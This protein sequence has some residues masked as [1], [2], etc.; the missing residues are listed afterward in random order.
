MTMPDF[1]PDELPADLDPTD[2]AALAATAAHLLGVRPRPS[3]GFR[4]RLRRDILARGGVL[5]RRPPRLRR[6]VLGALA[7]GAALVLLAASGLTGTGPLAPPSGGGGQ[8]A[9]VR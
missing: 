7:A 6:R 9:Q 3:A 8:A 2:R 5:P 1:D 4:G